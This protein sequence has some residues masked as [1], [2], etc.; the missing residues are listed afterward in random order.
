RPALSLP[1]DRAMRQLGVRLHRLPAS[2]RA[3]CHPAMLDE[4]RRKGLSEEAPSI[5]PGLDDSHLHLSAARF[6][7]RRTPTHC[8]ALCY[9]TPAGGV[10]SRSRLPLRA[11]WAFAVWQ[12]SSPPLNGSRSVPEMALD[13]HNHAGPRGTTGASH[14]ASEPFIPAGQTGPSTPRI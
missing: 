1:A 12:C 13:A 8:P 4:L 2:H 7:C 10:M 11:G 3:G 9:D 14:L 6:H 5:P